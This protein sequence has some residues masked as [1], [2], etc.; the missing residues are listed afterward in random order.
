VTTLASTNMPA[1]T[2]PYELGI[3]AAIDSADTGSSPA[4]RPSRIILPAAVGLGAAG[5]MMLVTRGNP[6]G[7]RIAASALGAAGGAA[8]VAFAQAQSAAS[9][10]TYMVRFATEPDYSQT[11]GTPSSVFE[12][13]NRHFA[14]QSPPVQAALD[15]M[16]GQGLIARYT[17]MPIANG[18]I[19][20]VRADRAEM[21]QQR[22]STTANVGSVERADE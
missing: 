14:Q 2:Q 3:S 5:L 16:Q 1:R 18:Y 17:P 20:D 13:L 11:D 10:R 4:L 9:E 8:F 7:I 21:F 15:A 22:I 19:V 6:P 12:L